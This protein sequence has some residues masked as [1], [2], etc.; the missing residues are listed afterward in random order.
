[1]GEYKVNMLGLSSQSLSLNKEVVS[2]KRKRDKSQRTKV[3]DNNWGF[4]VIRELSDN[5]LCNFKSAII[6]IAAELK[7]ILKKI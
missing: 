1:M 7:M 3:F 4:G 2:F 5:D 6:H